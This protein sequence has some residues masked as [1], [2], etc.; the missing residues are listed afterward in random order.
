MRRPNLLLALLLVLGQLALA[1]HQIGH[2][3]E[4][5]GRD[6]APCGACVLADH[7][8]GAPEAVVVT[9]GGTW[10]AADFRPLARSPQALARPDEVRARAPPVSLS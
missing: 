7:L 8:S 5:I 3:L 9:P 2:R 4:Q 1:W 10:V 6:E